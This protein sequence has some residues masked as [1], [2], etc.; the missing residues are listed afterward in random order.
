VGYYTR[1]EQGLWKRHLMLILHGNGIR[2]H[3]LQQ[4]GN[5]VRK[6]R[7]CVN[8]SALR[9]V[10]PSKLVLHAKIVCQKSWTCLYL[11]ATYASSP[12][13]TKRTG[14]RSSARNP[15]LDMNAWY[16]DPKLP[17]GACAHRCRKTSCRD[18]M[19]VLPSLEF[20]HRVFLYCR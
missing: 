14:G 8:S 16:S 1:L 11:V 19:V 5:P 2:K 18:S 4:T 6:R 15:L 7:A 13:S 3:E 9:A 17:G 10:S 20:Y 12:S